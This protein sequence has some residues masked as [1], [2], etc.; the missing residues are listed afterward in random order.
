MSGEYRSARSR[1]LAG[2]LLAAA[3]A[4]L[5]AGVP[6]PSKRDADRLQSKLVLIL[7]FGEEASRPKQ[8][9]HSTV[10]TEPEVNAYL[11]FSA[12]D[13]IPEGIVEPSITIV[14]D[15][16]LA[17][18][19][20]VDLDAVKKQKERGWLDPLAYMSGR[21]PVTAAGV[22]HARDG[23]ARF[24]LQSAQISGVTVPKWVLQ[25]LVSYYTR[26]PDNPQGIGLDDPFELPA[27]IREIKVGRGEA[28]VV[29]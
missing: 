22:L 20:L 17:G 28:I 23:L 18:R 21:M 4:G 5:S 29:Q 26:T 14:G 10:I 1:L 15:G 24:E 27:R 9:V 3:C 6:G 12:A 8:P 25:E 7:Q 13:Q 11:K 16:R 19:A 2:V